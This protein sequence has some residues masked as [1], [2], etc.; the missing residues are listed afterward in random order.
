MADF[1]EGTFLAPTCFGSTGR[2]PAVGEALGMSTEFVVETDYE[3]D[4]TISIIP[5]TDS[6]VTMTRKAGTNRKSK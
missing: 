3:V 6:K 4:G 1:R 5:L 2:S